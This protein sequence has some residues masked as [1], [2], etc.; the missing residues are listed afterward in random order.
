MSF[1]KIIGKIHL[2]LGLVSG[3]VVFVI[4]LTGCLYAFQEEIQNLTQSYRFVEPQSKPFLPPSVLKSIAEKQL[5]DKHLH[6][7]LYMDRGKAAQVSFFHFEPSYYY[8]VYLNP[9]DGK[10][11]KVKDMDSDFFRIVL[12]GHFYFWLPPA[13]GQPFVAYS[14]LVFV[15]LLVTGIVLWWPKNKAATKQRFWFNWKQNL[16]WKRKNYDLH[17]ILGFYASIFILILALT[18]LV[19]GFQWFAESVYGLAGGKKSLLFTEPI[20]APKPEN[21]ALNSPAIDQIWHRMQA[22]YPKAAVLEVHVPESDTSAI[23]ASANPDAGTYW[24]TDYRYFDQYSLQEIK[25]GHL[26]GRFE[27]ASAADKLLRMNY[28]LHVGAVWG[29]AGKVLAF[30]V[31]LVATSLPVTGFLIWWGRRKKVPKKV[32]EPTKAT[33]TSGGRL[34]LKS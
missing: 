23:A 27:E 31:S 22:E 25:V 29:L 4:S 24:K 13:I 28:D 9:Y 19:W 12:Q 17:N 7:V 1:K 20:S 6:A 26:Y 3:V 21:L 15:V 16:K 8:I 10:V 30:L 34:I 18:G 5:P 11:L 14:T 32:L 33:K 2:W